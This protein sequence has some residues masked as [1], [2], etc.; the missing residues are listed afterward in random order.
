MEARMAKT[1]M[2][3]WFTT[4]GLAEPRHT[5]RWLTNACLLKASGAH[6]PLTWILLT[7]K[8]AAVLDRD[9]HRRVPGDIRIGLGAEW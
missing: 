3:A 2:A 1:A 8:G 9:P 6:V 7:A 4:A 5:L